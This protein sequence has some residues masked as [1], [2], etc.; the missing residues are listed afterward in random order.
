MAEVTIPGA[1]FDEWYPRECEFC[2][3]EAAL[4][5]EDPRCRA[6]GKGEPHLDGCPAIASGMA[7]DCTCHGGE[8]R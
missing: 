1:D 6:E 4:A 2:T 8:P 3:L 7:G 5:C